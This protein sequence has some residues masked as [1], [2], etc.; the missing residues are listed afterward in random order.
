MTISGITPPVVALVE[1][2]LAP[3]AGFA[4][5]AAT[6][7]AAGCGAS[8]AATC[9]ALTSGFCAAGEAWEAVGGCA[10]LFA[11]AWGAEAA[12]CATAGWAGVSVVG[13]AGVSTDEA[14]LPEIG[15]AA[16]R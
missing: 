16:C 12:S 3:A 5:L 2:A 13:A 6:V 1:G 15:R 9:P 14:G 7:A 11:E 10:E 4:S 8:L